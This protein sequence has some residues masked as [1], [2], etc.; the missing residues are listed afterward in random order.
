MNDQ[1]DFGGAVVASS[2]KVHSE[3]MVTVLVLAAVAAYL[4][5]VAATMWYAAVEGRKRHALPFSLPTLPAP[6]KLVCLGICASS[7]LVQGLAAADMYLQ[8]RVVQPSAYDYFQYMSWARLLGTSHAHLFGFMMLY[9]TLA[10]LF[11]LST[12]PEKVKHLL[13]PIVL[14]A[15]VFDVLAWYGMKGLSARFEWLAM[16]TGSSNGLASMAIVAFIVKDLR[17]RLVTS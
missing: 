11:G 6:A 12:A 15:G 2:Q 8:T 14:W 5:T 1:L 9:G 16:V 13:I 4:G 10:L 7:L 17:P 3:A